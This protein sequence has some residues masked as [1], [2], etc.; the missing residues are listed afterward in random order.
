MARNRISFEQKAAWLRERQSPA[1]GPA[2]ASVC[3]LERHF[4][5]TEIAERWSLSTDAVQKRFEN[6]PGVLVLP[7]EG[8]P[9][10]RRYRTLRIPESVL[11]RVYRRLTNV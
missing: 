4:S 9:H 1:S 10:K 6:E 3:F 5:V 8:S 2:P 11:K 7:G